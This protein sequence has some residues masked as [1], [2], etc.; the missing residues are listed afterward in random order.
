[1]IYF[2]LIL[3]GLIG[4]FIA[5]LLGVGGG[6]IF[7]FVLS[8]YFKKLGIDPIEMPRFLISNSIFATFFAGL[9][10]SIKNYKAGNFYFREVISCAIPGV[11]AT[12]ILSFL[13]TNF[14]WYSKK[15]FTIFFVVLIGFFLYKLLAKRKNEDRPINVQVSYKKLGLIGFLSGIVS[16]LSGL[17][18]GVVMIPLMTELLKIP[19][20]K[21]AS[22][23]LGVIPFFAFA[24]SLFYGFTFTPSIDLPHSGGYLVFH[25]A[26]PLAI[27]V[28]AA[29]PF[30]VRVAK[31]LPSTLIKVMFATLLAIVALKMLFDYF[32]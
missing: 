18:G 23:S 11:V 1:M 27:G 12:L 31:L 8:I 17:G 2:Y 25:A 14:S 21:A 19:I 32:S 9:S 28:V 7:V 30:G 24:M 6:L 26:L 5:G 4:G 29:A 22:I 15:Q 3:A 10:S 16:A 20:K 13:I